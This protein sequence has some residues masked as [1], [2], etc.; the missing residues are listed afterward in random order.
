MNNIL[1]NLY[2]HWPKQIVLRFAVSK[3]NMAQT[4]VQVAKLEPGRTIQ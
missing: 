3:L 4:N 2:V 1:L